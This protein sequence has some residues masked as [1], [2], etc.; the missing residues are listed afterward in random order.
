MD[1]PC[2]D[3]QPQE[4]ILDVVLRS[5][6]QL[7]TVTRVAFFVNPR[8]H[9]LGVLPDGVLHPAINDL[10]IVRAAAIEPDFAL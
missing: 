1:I 3:V 6:Q 10:R 7:T 5:R 4:A 8:A 9:S 2:V